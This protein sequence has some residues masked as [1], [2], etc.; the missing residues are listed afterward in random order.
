MNVFIKET[1][2]QGLLVALKNINH[3]FKIIA[4]VGNINIDFKVFRLKITNFADGSYEAVLSFGKITVVVLPGE[5]TVDIGA[6]ISIVCDSAAV[7]VFIN[8][9]FRFQNFIDDAAVTVNIVNVNVTDAD[10]T[11]TRKLKVTAE[12]AVI[13]AAEMVIKGGGSLLIKA[14]DLTMQAGNLV[15][16]VATFSVKAKD[17]LSLAAVMGGVSIYGGTGVVISASPR[18]VKPVAST[19]HIESD[20]II[21]RGSVDLGRMPISVAARGD[22]TKQCIESLIQALST[23][24]SAV[25]P[26]SSFMPSGPCAVGPAG[27]ALNIQV[28]KIKG[29][30]AMIECKDVKVS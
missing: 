9:G 30:V 7:K 2:D 10:A 17:A 27:T 29:I 24:A 26:V 6:A 11:F 28:Q 22:K 5:I 19:V 1:P 15:N 4:A 14:A 25:A 21:G 16:N 3:Y 12:E 18:S 23:F 20:R 13:S 8:K